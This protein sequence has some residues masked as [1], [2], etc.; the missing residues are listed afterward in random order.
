LIKTGK[1]QC[2]YIDNTL[3]RVKMQVFHDKIKKKII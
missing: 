1:K 2:F 3:P